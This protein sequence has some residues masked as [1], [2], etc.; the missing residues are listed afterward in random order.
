MS[1]TMRRAAGAVAVV[2]ALVLGLPM[3]GLAGNSGQLPRSDANSLLVGQIQS[4]LTTATYHAGE[5]PPKATTLA[6]VQLH[7]HHVLN[8]LEG[9]A[10]A[11]FSA[12]AGDPCQRQGKGI[13]P[14][15]Q[16]A[17]QQNLPGAHA[18]LQE[19]HTSQ[20]LALQALAS[21]SLTKAQPF[22]LTVSKHL[23]TAN[24]YISE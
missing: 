4:E 8:C 20:M 12:A 3:S 13:I 16:A 7:L 9:P 14:D 1:P 11:D 19:A 24:K 23:Q 6:G 15:L 2:C 5:L 17:V 18:A 22:A 21:T 10:G